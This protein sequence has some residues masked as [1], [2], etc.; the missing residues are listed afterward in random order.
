MTLQI[1]V[2]I[3]ASVLAIT[4]SHQLEHAAFCGQDREPSRV[5]F[6]ET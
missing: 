2:E 4:A 5:T 3:R 6:D 1:D